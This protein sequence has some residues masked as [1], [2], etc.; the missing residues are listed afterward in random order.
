MHSNLLVI[1]IETVPDA[2]HHEGDGFPKVL[3]HQV[4][5]IG[6]LEAEAEKASH[7][8]IF[9][10]RELRCGGEANYS[11]KDLLQGFFQYFERL[12][13]RLITFNGRAF[14][15][16]VLKYRAMKYGIQ[17]PWFYK[18]DERFGYGYRYGNWHIDLMDQLSDFGA[19]KSPRLDEVSRLLGFPGK[20][21][22]DGSRVAGLYE[23]GRIAE[24]RD[25]C[26]TDVLN[27]WLVYLRYALH[28]ADIDKESY[29]SSIAD[30]LAYID[31]EKEKR[32]HLME[33][34]E[35]WEEACDGR[36]SIE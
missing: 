36:F 32:P 21:G 5:A 3:F 25:Y 6:F 16:P 34:F 19:S 1:D 28:R 7:G 26:E 12:K 18:A 4:V 10:L 14:D 20:F 29:N 13:P 8:E 27:T 17:A 23:E 11:E 31:A 22:V 33:F 15:V 35:A 24:I 9:R 30:V 2:E